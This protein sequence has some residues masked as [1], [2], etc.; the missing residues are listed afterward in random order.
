MYPRGYQKPLQHVVALYHTPMSSRFERFMAMRYLRSVRGQEEGS[1]FVWF[2]AWIATGGVAL[3]TAALLLALSVVRGFGS[4]IEAKITGFGAHVQ[5][6]TFRDVPI[7]GAASIR[8]TLAS[9]TGVVDAAIV[10]QEFALLRR[11]REHIEG[12]AIRGMEQPPAYFREQIVDGSFDTQPDTSRHAGLV[13]GKELADLLE[14]ELGQIV[15][16]FSMRSA[17]AGQTPYI[18]GLTA[19]RAKTFRIAGIYE[20][21]LANFDAL[22][23]FTSLSAARELLAYGPDQATRF[24]VMLSEVGTAREAAQTIEDRVGFPLMARSIYDVYGGLFAWINLQKSIIP[25]VISIIV[26]VA[27]FNI[28]GTLLMTILEK[29]REIGI[30]KSMGASMRSIRKQFIWSGLLIGGVGVAL[31]ESLA[32]ALVL[33]QDKYGLISLPEEAYY[34]TTA[35]VELHAFDFLLTGALA[36][37]LCVLAAYVPARVA[38]G[39][40]AIRAIRFR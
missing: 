26:M 1:R 29:T 28:I 36:M 3:G 9:T 18:A 7:D 10:V 14:V 34:L 15:T 8:D 25:V 32:F 30:L 21:S 13:I 4:E 11:S 16:S 12:V 39:I 38:A 40:E 31:G 20:T 23:V 27:A 35:P 33:L 22:Y 37:A 2:I 24:D 6:E 5:V 17:S 19:P